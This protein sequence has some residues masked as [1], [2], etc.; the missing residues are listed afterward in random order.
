MT[1]YSTRQCPSQYTF[2]EKKKRNELFNKLFHIGSHKEKEAVQISAQEI[3]MVSINTNS[4]PNSKKDQ[5]NDDKQ[6][7]RKKR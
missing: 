6:C 5:S 7:C 2:A 3:T 4:K 1:Q